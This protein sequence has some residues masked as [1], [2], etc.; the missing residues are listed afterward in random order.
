MSS[1]IILIPAR[2]A[3][4]RFPGKP[5]ALINGKPM[6]Q[7]VIDNC[8]N[9]GLDYCVVTD[10]QRIED[11]ITGINEK[12]VRVDDDVAT[13]S[14]RIALAYER[15]FK[16]K[17]YDLIINV[18]GDEPL[19]KAKTILDIVDS[20]L[21]SK[22]DIYTGLNERKST[23]SDFDNPNIVKC[24][25]NKET[26]SCFYFSRARVPFSREEEEYSWF[27]HIGIYS[28]RPKALVDFVALSP[29]I[30]ENLEKLEQL[31]AIDNGMT[32]HAKVINVK[33]IGVDVE[34]DIKKVEGVFCE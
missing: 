20:H 3:S 11:F 22:A 33:L 23:D 14:E 18:Q 32:I 7:Y 1:S 4:S 19:L 21:S 29:S 5:L 6:I 34:D 13:G 24:I 8:K 12:V 30:H 2:F 10:D 31:R 15:F 25:Y 28:Y 9:T 17:D 16:D 27:Q 26:N